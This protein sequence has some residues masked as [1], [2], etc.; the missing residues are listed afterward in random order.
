MRYITP[1]L[2]IKN[3]LGKH[4]TPQWSTAILCFCG[5]ISSDGLVRAFNA[6]PFGYSVLYG[7]NE[8]VES[9][10]VYE[11][12]I[13]GKNVGIITRAIWGGPQVA[14]LVE[15]LAYLG[16][17]Y[18]IG[19]GRAGSI[20][21]SLQ[22]GQQVMASSTLPTDGTTQAYNQREMNPDPE[23][24]KLAIRAGKNVSYDI[25]Q[26]T[27]ATVDA[28][29]RE[30]EETVAIWRKQGAQ[31][32]SMDS[33][34]FYAASTACNLKSIWIGYI[35]DRLT[36]K[37]EDWHWNREEATRLSERICVELVRLVLSTI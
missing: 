6:R 35:T 36:D 19:D 37:W 7:Q 12:T 24:K 31:A 33:S 13:D 21:S 20:D 5:R 17:K 11:A 22:L 29:Y 23:L 28:L 25:Q 15:E 27:I 26:V 9:P 18:L 34:P 4:P 32:I 30:T 3:R 16:I 14:I 8:F 10:F 1:E 2:L